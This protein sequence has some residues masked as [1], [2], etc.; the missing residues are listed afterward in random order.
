MSGENP[1]PGLQMAIFS[2][3]PY[4]AERVRRWG[5][6]SLWS[7]FIRTL[8]PSNPNDLPKAPPPN[9]TASCVRAL[10]YAF[11]GDTSQSIVFCPALQ[12]SCPSHMQNVF[13]PSQQT[14]R[15]NSFQHQLQ[16]SS[17]AGMVRLEIQFI[18]GQIPLPQ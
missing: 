2:V 6:H 12:N 16:V 11:E 8:S 1:L 3:C 18:L 9:T 15:L 10:I 7:R 5:E 17:K 14:N 13:I 4:M